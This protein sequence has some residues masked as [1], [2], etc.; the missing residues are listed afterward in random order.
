[1]ARLTWA[2]KLNNRLKRNW[3]IEIDYSKCFQ[4]SACGKRTYYDHG[5]EHPISDVRWERVYQKLIPATKRDTISIEYNTS[6]VW[7]EDYEDAY[8]A[9]REYYGTCDGY[10]IITVKTP[11][12]RQKIEIDTR[13]VY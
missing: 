12:G 7:S 11:T 3:G 9:E 2:K 4:A 8:Y 13:Y 10:A 6:Y 1:M 5:E